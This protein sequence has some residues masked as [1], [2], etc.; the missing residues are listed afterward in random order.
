ML[1]PLE[2]ALLEVLH[3]VHSE[4]VPKPIALPRP[5]DEILCGYDEDISSMRDGYATW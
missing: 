1:I 4:I 5:D 2:R 3:P